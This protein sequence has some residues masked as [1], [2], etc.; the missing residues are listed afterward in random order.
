MADFV[1][2][3]SKQIVPKY[4][5]YYV[6][7][8]QLLEAVSLLKEREALSD[9]STNLLRGILLPK[10]FTFGDT[11][12]I[13]GIVEQ[14]PEVR[15]ISLLEHELSKINHFTALEV[16]TILSSLRQV[17]KR[18]ERIL[19]GEES[20]RTPKIVTAFPSSA[21]HEDLVDEST[22]EGRISKLHSRLV[23]ISDEL[24]TLE[25]YVQM[26]LVIFEKIASEF[27]S[28]F[29]DRPP[30]TSWFV[31][32]LADESF[33][34]IPFTGLFTLIANLFS[35]SNLSPKP[36]QVS[37]GAL[38]VLPQQFTLRTKLLLASLYP[39]DPLLISVPTRSEELS[40]SRGVFTSSKES[41]YL[42]IE[43]ESS[44]IKNISYL[45]GT[46]SVVVSL[47]NS[48]LLVSVPLADLDEYFGTIKLEKSM[49]V[50][51]VQYD[52]TSIG[53]WWIGENIR[54]STLSADR[55]T[56][57]VREVIGGSL[58]KSVEP[59]ERLEGSLLMISEDEIASHA[60][61]ADIFAQDR[62]RLSDLA[63]VDTAMQTV[64]SGEIK[65][66][67]SVPDRT[68]EQFFSL[69]PSAP[70][71]L[72]SV[73]LP[74][75]SPSGGMLKQAPLN[76]EDVPTVKMIYPKNFMANER[77]F[78]AWVSAISVQTGIGLSMVSKPG[79]SFIGSIVCLI[80]LTFLWWS[81][82]VFVRRFRKMQ[83]AGKDDRSDQAVFFSTKLPTAF[84]FVQILV[85]VVQSLIVLF[86]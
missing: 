11:T 42:S 72:L 21:T 61:F 15:F 55:L 18:L 39:I 8:K 9:T 10:D 33:R 58:P 78:L 34:N 38:F 77:A 31:P 47:R 19:K 69:P 13:H 86:G 1:D 64:P 35:K 80:A 54:F 79:L 2:E 17:S 41:L 28:K 44:P 12:A 53:Q 66:Q 24:L 82:L 74:V 73:S 84:G 26:N 6:S 3:F 30:I 85:L 81:V 71:P 40:N 23:T 37:T 16:K 36:I 43:N 68:P 59:S 65:R 52:R 63:M 32:R 60:N 76:E 14:R 46:Q 62:I 67:T 48:Q 5:N 22:V 45:S 25:H 50:K 83:N 57:L 27:D 4:E 75:A 51:I 56:D 70:T 49:T 29:S 7:Y 20:S